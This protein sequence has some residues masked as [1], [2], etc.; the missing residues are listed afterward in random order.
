MFSTFALD[1]KV[2]VNV[3][4]NRTR[5][6]PSW[7]D[8]RSDWIPVGDHPFD[9][10]QINIKLIRQS[11]SYDRERTEITSNTNIQLTRIPFGDHT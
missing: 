3:P 7:H 8:I 6:R 10:I 1:F 5:L 9:V 4:V 2:N 11:A